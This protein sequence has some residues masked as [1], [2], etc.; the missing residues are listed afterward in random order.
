[1]I[2]VI[3]VS[4]QQRS[5]RYCGILWTPTESQVRR[6][7]YACC[8]CLWARHP[9]NIGKAPKRRPTLQQRMENHVPVTESGCWLWLGSQ[10]KKGYGLLPAGR[11]GK[12]IFA[13]RAMFEW[14]RGPIPVG[15]CVCHKCDTPLCVNPDH[16]FLGT[17]ADNMADKARKG[18][19]P[20]NPKRRHPP[21]PALARDQPL[22]PSAGAGSSTN[23]V[24]R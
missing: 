10:D 21:Q 13:H 23:E 22:N 15:L 3:E 6:S 1:M 18:R 14:E 2:A 7:Q 12:S 9:R 11:R 8:P 24:T 5:C 19:A 16:L 20:G 4:P 17:H